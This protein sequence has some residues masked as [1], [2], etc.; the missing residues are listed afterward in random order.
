[1]DWTVPVIGPL[2]HQIR[3]N[4]QPFSKLT[5]M[6]ETCSLESG[7]RGEWRPPQRRVKR[8]DGNRKDTQR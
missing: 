5:F 2:S 8:L 7:I 6:Q 3:K 4:L 1:M